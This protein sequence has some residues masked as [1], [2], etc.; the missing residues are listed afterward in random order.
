MKNS[1]ILRKEILQGN[2]GSL[3]QELYLDK[4]LLDYQTQRY[5][6]AIEKFEELYG[7]REIEIYSAPGRSEV[8]GNH[9]DHQLG[10]VL[11][12][13]INLDAI[14]IVSRNEGNVIRVVSDGYDMV[15]VDIRDLEEK[16]S[17]EGTT[18]ALVRGVAAGLQKEG[19]AA[20]SR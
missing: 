8:G 6:T 18:A 2:Y 9:T 19:Y 4:K 15:E 10:M 13:S 16:Y 11:A 14:A 7:E 1:G 17:E 20:E 3:L 5:I 12:A